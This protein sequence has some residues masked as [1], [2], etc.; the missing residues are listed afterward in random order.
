MITEIITTEEETMEMS[1][2]RGNIGVLTDIN[3]LAFNELFFPEL[4]GGGDEVSFYLS[5]I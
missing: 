1:F 5:A 3:A 2:N 4:S